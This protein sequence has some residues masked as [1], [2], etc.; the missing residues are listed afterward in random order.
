MIT[1]QEI[2]VKV[3]E[4][5]SSKYIE[6]EL[7]KTGLDVL[8]WA[9]TDFDDKYYTLNLAVVKNVRTNFLDKRIFASAPWH[10]VPQ[11]DKAKKSAE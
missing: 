2:K 10:V 7:K 1:T 8:R 4:E 11:H 3:P 5:F 6:N 9:I